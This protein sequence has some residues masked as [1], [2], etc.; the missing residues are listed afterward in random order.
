VLGIYVNYLF[1]INPLL[2]NSSSW[3]A[4][5]FCLNS[6]ICNWR[7]QAA[8]SLWLVFMPCDF[9]FYMTASL[10]F[11]C[12]FVR[13]YFMEFLTHVLQFLTFLQIW[14]FP[15][16][17][18]VLVLPFIT[19]LLPLNHSH[20]TVKVPLFPPHTFHYP[21]TC[22]CIDF[23][24]VITYMFVDISCWYERLGSSVTVK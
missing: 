23:R 17:T 7:P 19:L 10:S 8:L 18:C 21:C 15:T 14:R 6:G 12:L 3:S 2:I 4:S 22:Y 13:F 24:Y 16:L 5:G 9:H 1:I 11:V 20:N